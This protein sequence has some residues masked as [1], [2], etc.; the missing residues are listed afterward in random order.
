MSPNKMLICLAHPDDESFGMGGTIAKY[1]NEGTE[2]TLVCAT[3]GEA[4]TV[5]SEFL[6]HYESIAALREH[7]LACAARVLGI[8]EVIYM[9]YRDS[10]M[11]GSDDNQHIQSFVQADE[12]E[13][14][15]KLI[16]IMENSKPDIVITFDETGGYH[17]PD[18]IAIHQA[19]IHAFNEIGAKFQPKALYV[20]ARSRKRLRRMVRFMPLMG[21]NPKKVG[22][23]KDIDLTR[24]VADGDTIPHVAIDYGEILAQKEEA[25]R[26]HASQFDGG[27]AGSRFFMRL[28]RRIVK[29]Q[30][31]FTRYHPPAT[32]VYRG[33][34][35]FEI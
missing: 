19:T 30:D 11:A 9:G 27:G 25:D 17:H 14:V 24:L 8:H 33:N 28:M 34:D 15:T 26:C 29:N 31:V 13:V 10:G 21:K 22:R 4:G 16:R 7:E 3:K 20:M 5:D 1:A 23:N 18:H 2:I 32:D 35:L 6:T 12:G